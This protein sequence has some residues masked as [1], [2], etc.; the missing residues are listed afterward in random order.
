MVEVTETARIGLNADAAWQR[1]GSFG[2]VGEWHPMLSKVESEGDRPGARRHVETTE[3]ARQVERLEAFDPVSH[4]YRYV[5][6]ETAL[7]V[8]DYRAE[9]CVDGDGEGEST[10]IWSARFEVQSASR[11]EDVEAI[12]RFLKAGMDDLKK[13]YPSAGFDDW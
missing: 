10:V 5:M 4:D 7:P 9:F 2:S 11:D 3:G 6:E 1:L 12:R 8:S 13:R